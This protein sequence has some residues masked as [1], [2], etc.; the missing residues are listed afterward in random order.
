M[1]SEPKAVGYVDTKEIA[2]LQADRLSSVQIGT[3]S[4]RYGRTTPLYDEQALSAL[5]AE[6]KGLS[7]SLTDTLDCEKDYLREI[8]ELRAEVEALRQLV[9]DLS[10]TLAWREFGE[11]RGYSEKLLDTSEVLALAKMKLENPA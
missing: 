5:R 9:A 8:A 10:Q 7:R 4:E 3:Y 11:C 2:E 6:V 1:S